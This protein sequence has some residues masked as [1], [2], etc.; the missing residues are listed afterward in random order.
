MVN[1]P[2]AI[3]G[4]PPERRGARGDDAAHRVRCPAPSFLVVE[5]RGRGWGTLP[6]L[7]TARV[8]GTAPSL[9]ATMGARV[10]PPPGVSC[11][12]ARRLRSAF[13]A[14]QGLSADVSWFRGA[15]WDRIPSEQFAEATGLFGTALGGPPS[16]RGQARRANGPSTL[17][18]RLAIALTS[19]VVGLTCIGASRCRH[20]GIDHTGV[21]LPRD[22]RR[23]YVKMAPLFSTPGVSSRRQ[24]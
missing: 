22:R 15:S 5:G 11:P 14:A 23:A 4:A 19:P 12:D 20:A 16:C 2:T 10:R 9:R 1:G 17:E 21:K 13:L 8:P 6:A 7:V 18:Q 3:G 24:V